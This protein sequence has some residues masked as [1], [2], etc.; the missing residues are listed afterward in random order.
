MLQRFVLFLYEINILTKGCAAGAAAAHS[1]AVRK[2][3]SLYCWVCVF[4]VGCVSVRA[5]V[6]ARVVSCACFGICSSD[7]IFFVPSNMSAC[8]SV[9]V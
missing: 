8:M 5:S 1:C 3:G 2:T 6:A 9:C 4:R 7:H